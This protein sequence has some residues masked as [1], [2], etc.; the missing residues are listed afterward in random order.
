[1]IKKKGALI[2]IG[3]VALIIVGI[4]AYLGGFRSF[5]VTLAERGDY[6]LV[7]HYYSGEY[8]SDSLKTLF[9]EAKSLV[10]NGQLNGN[11]TIVHFSSAEDQDAVDVF[12]GVVVADTPED[13]PS[14]MELR[15]I[16]G[17]KVIRAVIT[18]HSSVRPLRSTV[19]ERMEAFAAEQNV[20]LRPL[21][22][23]HYL[24]ENELHIERIGK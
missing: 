3:A 16:E 21:V 9:F 17:G 10:E 12:M 8:D 22:L 18:A 24:S 13:I 4:Y 6:Q 23:E 2:I 11:L 1:M 20:Q 19:D 7:G 15:T 5:E 14:H